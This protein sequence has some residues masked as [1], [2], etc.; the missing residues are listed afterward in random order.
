MRTG[1]RVGF[2]VESGVERGV[3]ESSFRIDSW[4]IKFDE[5]ASLSREGGQFHVVQMIRAT[6][7]EEVPHNTVELRRKNL[8]DHIFD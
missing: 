1:R 4:G 2:A 6:Y 7:G 3:G 8:L 5:R